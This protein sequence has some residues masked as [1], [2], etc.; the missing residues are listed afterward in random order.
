MLSSGTLSSP[1]WFMTGR[2]RF[3]L[4]FIV[5]YIRISSEGLGRTNCGGF[6]RAKVPLRG[7]RFIGFFL[8]MGAFLFLGKAFGG[9]RL[10]LE[11]RFLLGRPLEA[12]FPPLTIFAE[13]AWLWLIDVGF[14]SQMG[15]RWIISFFI[16]VWQMPCG[17]L[18]SAGLGWAGLCL[19]Q[20]GSCSPAGGR[21]VA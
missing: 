15:N 5:A 1:V 8:L 4:R 6:L 10:R 17:M 21:E 13:E 14:A 9:R 2:W 20:L 11:W 16:A 18:F 19:I 12:R 3:W 7:V